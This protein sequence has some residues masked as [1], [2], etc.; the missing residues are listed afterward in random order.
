M[1]KSLKTAMSD[2]S[3]NKNSISTNMKS[4]TTNENG[5]ADTSKQLSLASDE[6]KSDNVLINQVQQ[7][8]Q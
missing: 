3:A 8:L 4:I 7:N 1:Q 6:W 2:I 5:I